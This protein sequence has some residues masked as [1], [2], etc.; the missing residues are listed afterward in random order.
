MS[1]EIRHHPGDGLVSIGANMW[2][3]AEQKIAMDAAS[4]P[5]KGDGNMRT[6][7]N[8]RANL[9]HFATGI[10]EG[11]AVDQAGADPYRDPKAVVGAG[12]ATGGN[13]DPWTQSI[14]ENRHVNELASDK[15][16]KGKAFDKLRGFLGDKVKGNDRKAFDSAVEQLLRAIAGEEDPDDDVDGRDAEVDDGG[17]GSTRV[18]DPGRKSVLAGDRVRSGI[19]LDA[20]PRGIGRSTASA[21]AEFAAM[22]PSAGRLVRS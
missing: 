9:K 12:G 5:G 20:M 8:S 3:S 16:A 22:F 18:L 13:V 11:L 14:P 17:A 7:F 2:V 21:E 10:L 15:G 19:G 1:V 6:L 4:W